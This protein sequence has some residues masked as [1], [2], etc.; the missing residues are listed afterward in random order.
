M[1]R[2]EPNIKFYIVHNQKQVD[3]LIKHLKEC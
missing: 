1:Y 3:E 2:F